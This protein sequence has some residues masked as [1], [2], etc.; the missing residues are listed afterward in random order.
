MGLL[1]EKRIEPLPRETKDLL[2]LM[3]VFFRPVQESELAKTLGADP[4]VFRDRLQLL[5]REGLVEGELTGTYQLSSQALALDLIRLLA[6]EEK[7]LL[8]RRIADGLDRLQTAPSEEVAFHMARGGKE[9]EAL[10]LY[11]EEADR[12]AAEG[13]TAAA[14][15]CLVKA[16]ELEEEGSEE[17]Q[18]LTLKSARL[19]ILTG[20][21]Q[22]ARENL[23]RLG[24]F[25][26]SAFW[27]M[28]GTIAYK[29]R[30]FPS[31]RENFEKAIALIPHEGSLR[32]ILLRNAVGNVELQ[33]GN[34]TEAERIFRETLVQE[35]ALEPENRVKVTNNG[36][37]LLLSLKG[38]RDGAVRLYRERLERI[39]TAR[40]AERITLLNG[41]GFALLQGARWEEGIRHLREA[42]ALA[43]SSGALAAVFSILGNL[44]YGLMKEAR[45]ADCLP[46]LRK[47]ISYQERF[48]S[49]RDV[50]F[51]F[52]RL[53]GAYLRLNMEE[54]A[55][56][57]FEKGR[58]L[59]ESTSDEALTAWFVLMEGCRLR[60]TG[61]TERAHKLLEAS[62]RMGEELQDA[63][64]DGWSRYLLAEMSLDRNDDASC[65]RFIEGDRTD[66]RDEELVIRTDLLRVRMMIRKGERVPAL[67][68]LTQLENR[69][70]EQRFHETLSSVYHTRFKA[71][72]AMGRM[73]EAERQLEKGI[74]IIESL[75]EALPE[76]FR[77][78]YRRS[79]ER[80]QMY[81]DW[82]KVRP[83]HLKDDS[84]PLLS[85]HKDRQDQK[86]QPEGKHR[87]RGLIKRYL[88]LGTKVMGAAIAVIAL[89]GPGC[90]SPATPSAP[91]EIP[92]TFDV[93][94]PG[95]SVTSSSSA[96]LAVNALG[97]EDPVVALTLKWAE[98]D[99]LQCVQDADCAVLFPN[100]PVCA[101][102]PA[103]GRNYCS[104]RCD[105]GSTQAERDSNCNAL[106]N[107]ATCNADGVCL[108]PGSLCNSVPPETEFVECD[109]AGGKH[110]LLSCWSE[111]R[112]TDPSGQDDPNGVCTLNETTVLVRFIN[113]QKRDPNNTQNAVLFNGIFRS[114]LV[115]GQTC[116]DPT[117][118]EQRFAQVQ[119]SGGCRDDDACVGNDPFQE[120]QCVCKGSDG[121]VTRFQDDASGCGGGNGSC[122][123]F[124]P[125]QEH[126][127]SNDV[128]GVS[129]GAALAFAAGSD[130][131]LFSMDFTTGGYRLCN[132][133]NF[134]FTGTITVNDQTSN[135]TTT[136]NPFGAE[137][138]DD[139]HADGVCALKE[140]C[141][142][143][144]SIPADCPKQ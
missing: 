140:Y 94:T 57:C 19:L 30:D 43:E 103:S 33:A 52:L 108:G 100:G 12:F 10:R 45:Y 117:V 68:I 24:S 71:E 134:T 132:Q 92:S 90:P 26:S 13:R 131:G 51:N 72:S 38:D 80:L 106:G 119:A 62:F 35:E 29:E 126:A 137:L 99:N 127:E 11:K 23:Q 120:A 93:A 59:A 109:N 83:G 86:N 37:G 95:A 2:N 122:C 136:C 143:A 65:L 42:L 113:C 77:D 74:Q 46:L 55:A 139:G 9:D 96:T 112:K 15:R 105:S 98:V 39:G 89:F 7:A 129:D 8:H 36:L 128:T 135:T 28:K 125:V 85:P 91:L 124:I 50:A 138:I 3:A 17:W 87:F 107:N 44:T 142:P 63:G 6:P 18:E 40:V 48:G 53:G 116:T 31:A 82:E 58:R 101:K 115:I 84:N 56:E 141:G 47:T 54:A 70:L 14:C 81:E 32:R 61:D 64:I 20:A 79:R 144:S 75:A 73:D 110:E 118:L 114:A 111:A 69:C 49:P 34:R 60:E 16:R 27:E 5:I 102:D 121:K 41:L 66:H 1:Y 78:R 22:Q 123:R 133:N 97:L 104:Y 4:G 76:E 21:Y 130:H 25:P 67:E 88:H